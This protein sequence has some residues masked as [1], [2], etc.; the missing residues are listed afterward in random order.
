MSLFRER[1]RRW[2]ERRGSEEKGGE[3][4][5]RESET[6]R[7]RR[8]R[9]AYHAFLR[10]TRRDARTQPVTRHARDR[11]MRNAHDTLPRRYPAEPRA[12]AALSA[13]R[14]LSA[15]SLIDPTPPPRSL[16][17][18]QTR[19]RCV[20]FRFH[21]FSRGA[22]DASP[23]SRTAPAR[24]RIRVGSRFRSRR[25]PRSTPR[26]R[27]RVEARARAGRSF[28]PPSWAR[29]R[30]ECPRRG[31]PITRAASR[32]PSARAPMYAR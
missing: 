30:R 8:R 15:S 18:C 28:S 17:T 14:R 12:P 25:H 1:E 3:S 32:G 22:F 4:E 27:R 10:P 9:C 13:G 29:G 6:R 20:C 7:G 2:R 11:V 23:R 5:R 21:S 26:S 16:S 31:A 19:C 24:R